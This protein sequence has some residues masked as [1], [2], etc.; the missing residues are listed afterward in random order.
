MPGIVIAKRWAASMATEDSIS[1]DAKGAQRSMTDRALGKTPGSDSSGTGK[2]DSP[3]SLSTRTRVSLFIAAVSLIG[4]VAIV[5][6]PFQYTDATSRQRIGKLGSP[7]DFDVT[8][9]KQ[10]IMAGWPFRYLIKYPAAGGADE[11]SV[12]FAPL[13]LLYDLL[14]ASV[15]A[16][17]LF[18]YF[19]RRAKKS[20]SKRANVSIA[21]LLLLTLVLSCP[22]GWWQRASARKDE[23]SALANT[24]LDAG[25]NYTL[26]ASV[27]SLL[28]PYLPR[29]I[30]AKL[31]RIRE[32]R[33]EHPSDE[34]M[35]RLVQQRD[36]EVLRVGGGEYSLD[37]IGELVANPH[38]VDLRI[39]GRVLD[40]QTLQAIVANKRLHT[41]NLMRT[42]LSGD[43]LEVLDQLPNL[44]RLNLIHTDVKG[45]D[46]KTPAWSKTVIGLAISHPLPGDS[47][48]LH[49]NHWPNLQALTI[50]EYESQVNTT[51][52]KV[53]L[54]D[55]PQLNDLRLDIFQ[56][57][58][59]TLR[60]L[61]EVESISAV[62]FQW[63]S[64]LPRGAQVPGQI[65]CGHLEVDGLPKLKE[66]RFF[67]PGLRYFRLL[68]SPNV[69]MAGIGAFFRTQSA[70]TYEAQLTPE[71]AKA[72]IEGLGE[73]DGPRII[74]LDAVPMKGVDLAPLAK[75]QGISAIKLSQSGSNIHQ[76]MALEPMTW[77][78]RFEVKD[79]PIDD[80]GVQWILEAFP[81]L[82]HF[83][84]SAVPTTFNAGS[85]GGVDSIEIVN[86]PNLRTLDLGASQG[87]YYTKLRVV[88]SPNLST[89]FTPSYVQSL[90]ISNAP[91]LQ[92]LSVGYPI[93][94]GTSLSGLRD[95]QFFAVGGPDV[96]DQTIAALDHCQSLSTLTL[97]YPGVTTEGL[98][99]LKL[100]ANLSSLN[101]PGAAMDDSVAEHWPEFSL[102]TNLD[103]RD[104]QVSGKSVNQILASRA[105]TRLVLDRTN[106]K[107]SELGFLSEL[108]ELNELSLVGVGIE[109]ATL[110]SVLANGMLE[111]LDLSDSSVTPAILDL[112][113]ADDGPLNY[114]V[115]RNCELD[116]KTFAKLATKRRGIR[117]DVDGSNLSTE[118]MTMLL[119]NQRVVNRDEREEQIA[120]QTMMD[121]AAEGSFVQIEVQYPALIDIRIFAQ[122]AFASQSQNDA[123]F[124]VMSPPTIAPPPQ[125]RAF[126][127]FPSTVTT[128][129]SAPIATQVGQ[130]LG[131]MF[132][133]QFD[134]QP[135]D[136]ASEVNFDKPSDGDQ[137]QIR[138][139]TP[140]PSIVEE[141]D[142]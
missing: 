76:W 85:S 102:L 130:W 62:E 37:L 75:N 128:D 108:R 60:N 49:I 89:T 70:A 106:V 50:N 105:A 25:G 26:S 61:P 118:L 24:I 88:D 119:T 80:A 63:R 11:P 131:G 55:L 117:F 111:Y 114:V 33:H 109:K 54:S 52:M 100:N 140:S 41:L 141:T 1:T 27:P 51:P 40:P 5:N 67:C 107:A 30:S 45:R 74:D 16:A 87:E 35:R 112:L 126:G 12:R 125:G 82:E 120:L 9:P 93:P 101:L 139:D 96:T 8:T 21:D 81:E 10:P 28:K 15:V 110:E 53:E 22:L 84:C 135:D 121:M 39:A 64:R 99:K 29:P 34:L 42:N 17:L 56:K 129:A 69:E 97:A 78:K 127:I 36:L 116:N 142:E 122:E 47:D 134:P 104:T 20:T 38:L 86:R 103:L 19:L 137:S 132:G 48:S 90:E 138:D 66:L 31:M 98:R 46:I 73:S 4:A 18:V 113:A 32:V 72:L 133:S 13:A 57:F 124:G 65:W 58:D 92:G 6:W 59:L 3:R 14:L 43:S 44:Q 83:A 23:Q 123:G 115:L 94:E 7:V 136:A 79:C 91:S 77:L 2:G 95:L 68:N 71:V